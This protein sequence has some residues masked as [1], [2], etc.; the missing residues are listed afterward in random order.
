M[1]EEFRRAL[2]DDF[3]AGL[4]DAESDLAALENAGPD[5]FAAIVAIMERA[6]DDDADPRLVM[7]VRAL[8]RILDKSE[9]PKWTE[10]DFAKA[11]PPSE[12]PVAV[13][14]AFPRTIARL[15]SPEN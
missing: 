6:L 7:G 10:A 8:R 12:L 9:N 2:Q 14:A 5:D 11:K 13:R 4:A 1:S 15:D 3:A